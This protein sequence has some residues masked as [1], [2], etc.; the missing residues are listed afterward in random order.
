MEFSTPLVGLG[1]LLLFAGPV[2]ASRAFA[3][4]ADICARAAGDEAIVACTRAISSGRLHDRDLAVEYYNRG[5]NYS[6]KGDTDRAIAD[7]TEAVRLDP[8]YA[9]AYG[10]RGNAYLARLIHD[11]EIFERRM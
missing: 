2:S 4:D 11:G 1:A 5:I 7:Y 8:K 10:N 3:D 9:D 6:K